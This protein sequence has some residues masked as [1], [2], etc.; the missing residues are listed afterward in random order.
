MKEL[1]AGMSS[2]GLLT[3]GEVAE[4]VGVDPR[5]IYELIDA[6][7]LPAK[8]LKDH[9]IRLAPDDVDVYTTRR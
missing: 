5:R 3:V 9:G 4:L 7:Q 8:R 6:G 1:W 2:G